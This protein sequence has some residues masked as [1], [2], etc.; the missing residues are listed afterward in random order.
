MLVPV[1]V[2]A[3]AAS[4]NAGMIVVNP[5]NV[6]VVAATKAGSR[7]AIR[8]TLAAPRSRVPPDFT[9]DLVVIVRFLHIFSER[10]L[11]NRLGRLGHQRGVW[12]WV[13]V[14]PGS[15]HLLSPCGTNPSDQR[16]GKTSGR[17]RTDPES[18][19]GA[20]FA[21]GPPR[22]SGAAEATTSSRIR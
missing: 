13:F 19:T 22:A 16:L 4:A 11:G 21:P 14:L 10:K 9:Y 20:A 12:A 15:R 18:P 3:G 17:L 5:P 7:T 8:P 2:F 6:R 1:E